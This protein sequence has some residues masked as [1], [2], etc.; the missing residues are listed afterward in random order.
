VGTR[1]KIIGNVEL[2]RDEYTDAKLK[3]G[4]ASEL[5]NPRKNFKN[6]REEQEYSAKYIVPIT[7]LT[8]AIRIAPIMAQVAFDRLTY[9]L[10]V[11]DAA[12]FIPASS[13]RD[14]SLNNTVLTLYKYFNIPFNLRELSLEEAQG[15]WLTVEK[16]CNL[17]QR[18]LEGLAQPYKIYL[19]EPQS[20]GETTKALGFVRH[21]KVGE[22]QQHPLD[23]YFRT[24]QPDENGHIPWPTLLNT[25]DIHLRMDGLM[26]L[27]A[28]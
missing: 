3:P 10:Q 5:A 21:A 4:T 14:K 26:P 17:Y 23:T 7:R 11:R 18:A 28:K 2:W 9:L 25:G 1:F 19:Y 15:H 24:A 22:G 27:K 13:V 6:Q 8:E 16:I 12:E 20:T